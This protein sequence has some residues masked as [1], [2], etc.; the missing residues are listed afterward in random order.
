M[1]Q[2]TANTIASLRRDLA[3]AREIISDLIYLDSDGNYKTAFR[4]NAKLQRHF[5]DLADFDLYDR[6][7]T[8]P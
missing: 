4:P 5:P 6:K 7:G 3:R 2:R 8:R 1:T